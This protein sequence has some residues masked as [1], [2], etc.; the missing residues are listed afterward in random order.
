MMNVP[1]SDLGRFV[2]RILTNEHQ[3]S[4]EKDMEN[5]DKKY[6]LFIDVMETCIRTAWHNEIGIAPDDDDSVDPDLI[7]PKLTFA[8]FTAGD[9]PDDE[10]A[11]IM[12]IHEELETPMFSHPIRLHLSPALFF[13]GYDSDDSEILVVDMDNPTPQAIFAAVEIYYRKL[14]CPATDKLFVGRPMPVSRDG[15]REDLTVFME[16]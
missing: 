10:T 16:S 3:D 15:N 12:E 13:V 7:D 8:M 14:G 6:E 11:M 1:A 5:L 2:L 4:L 9:F